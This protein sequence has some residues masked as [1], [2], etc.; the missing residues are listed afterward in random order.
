MFYDTGVGVPAFIY[1]YYRLGNVFK[2]HATLL[3]TSTRERDANDMHKWINIRQRFT[4]WH[5]IMKSH[6]LITNH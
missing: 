5:L 1:W 6:L 2:W 3:C 4:F